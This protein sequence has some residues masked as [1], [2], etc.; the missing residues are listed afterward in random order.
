MRRRSQ[1]PT[2]ASINIWIGNMKLNHWIVVRLMRPGRR[3]R[4]HDFE[5]LLRIR[6]TL[7]KYWHRFLFHPYCRLSVIRPL[8]S[9]PVCCHRIS[10]NWKL[11][12][13]NCMHKGICH[14]QTRVRAC[15]GLR[16][17][18]CSPIYMEEWIGCECVSDVRRANVEQ[19]SVCMYLFKSISSA[20]SPSDAHSIRTLNARLPKILPICKINWNR[21]ICVYLFE[22]MESSD[23]SYARRWHGKYPNAFAIYRYHHR[24]AHNHFDCNAECLLI[25]FSGCSMQWAGPHYHGSPRRKLTKISIHFTL[26]VGALRHTLRL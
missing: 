6:Y 24:V 9:D 23:F 16:A 10:A 21:I 14:C 18:R 2:I 11:K 25:E 17:A 20:F 5:V 22:S 13:E 7:G 26:R 4:H 1:V 3:H 19:N 8:S 15:V 12:T